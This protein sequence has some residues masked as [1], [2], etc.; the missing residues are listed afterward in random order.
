LSLYLLKVAARGSISD[1]ERTRLN[2]SFLKATLNG[3]WYAQ[4]NWGSHFG[5]RIS[6]RLVW[7]GESLNYRSYTASGADPVSGSGHLGTFPAREEVSTLT[8]KALPEH[9]GE[10]SLVWDISETSLCRWESGLQKLHS[11]WDRPCFGPFI[12]CQEAGPNVRY[13]CIF[14][15]R[16]ELACREYSDHWNSGES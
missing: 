16:G 12:F 7:A 14:P 2:K 10:P 15:A 13:L 9:L 1:D 6:Q 3:I 11:F 8:R 4:S 5:S